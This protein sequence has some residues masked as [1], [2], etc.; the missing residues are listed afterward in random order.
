M[1]ITTNSIGNYALNN[2]SKVKNS[3]KVQQPAE[4]KETGSLTKAE[5][6]HFA[7]VYPD[8]KSDIIKYHFYNANGKYGG[9]AIG[10]NIDRRG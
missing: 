9:V 8:Q 4:V 10:N 5:V 7:K 3:A 6:E 2:L 1:K